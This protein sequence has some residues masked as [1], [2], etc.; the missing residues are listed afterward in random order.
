MIVIDLDLDDLDPPLQED[1]VGA[2]EEFTSTDHDDFEEVRLPQ[3]IDSSA[4]SRSPSP[5]PA[6]VLV[7]PSN[8]TTP[9]S[10]RAPSL[11]RDLSGSDSE[12][13][14]EESLAPGGLGT[15]KKR[16]RRRTAKQKIRDKERGQRL[17]EEEV[18]E[19]RTAKDRGPWGYAYADYVLEKYPS[20]EILRL[21]IDS[22]LDLHATK[23]AYEGRVYKKGPKELCT[24]EWVQDQGIKVVQWDGR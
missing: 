24:L 1:D 16:K 8:Q 7:P 21:H 5:Y 6:R 12:G 10:S 9:S 18:Q 23:S 13:D 20:V 11:K 2:P 4:N 3:G 15:G 22:E 14:Q 19:R 17:N